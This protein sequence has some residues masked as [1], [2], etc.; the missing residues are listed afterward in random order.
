M[1]FMQECIKSNIDQLNKLF[2][3]FQADQH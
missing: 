3:L 2:Q 1:P